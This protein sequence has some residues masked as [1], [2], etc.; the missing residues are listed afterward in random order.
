M[1]HTLDPKNSNLPGASRLVS[2]TIF[3]E[4]KT[5][6]GNLFFWMQ[7]LV[8]VIW[9]SGHRDRSLIPI[10]IIWKTTFKIFFEKIKSTNSNLFRIRRPVSD[11]PLIIFRDFTKYFFS[12]SENKNYQSP[13][14]IKTGLYNRIPGE[15]DQSR[16]TIF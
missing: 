12:R 11:L 3:L 14:S 1:P 5:S 10:Y 15:Q 8:S 16:K 9:I 2:I 13:G 7:R 4:N 6:L